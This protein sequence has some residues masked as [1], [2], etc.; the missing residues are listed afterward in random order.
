MI[1]LNEIKLPLKATKED[2]EKEAARLLKI[3]KSD[4][5][6]LSVYRKSLDSRKKHDIHFVYSVDIE[7]QLNEKSVI[8]PLPRNRASII[9]KYSYT[10]PQVKR[11]SQFRP[12]VVGFGPAGMFSALLLAKAGL[13]PLVLERGDDVD[14]R[15]K[16]VSNFWENKILDESS[17]V[18]FG[19]G[20]A[21]T[22]SDGK[23]TTGI[24]NSLCRE[25]LLRFV[26]YGAPEEI[27]WNKSA[28]IGTDKLRG[29]VK[30]I[31]KRII[32]LGGEVK[33]GCQMTGIIKA[34]GCVHGISY[35]D[36]NSSKI[37]FE[38]DTIILA[39][40]HSARDTYEYL[41]K[42]GLEIERKAFSVGLRIEHPQ[43]YI[44]KCQY[45][46]EYKNPLL[47]A[48]E[49]KLSDHPLHGRGA[50]TFCMCP[51][52]IVVNA[53]S[54]KGGVTVNGMS[55]FARDAENANSAILVGLEP[56]LFPSEHSLS[57]MYLQREIERKAFSVGGGYFPT[58]QL[59]KDFLNDTPS[60]K[61]GGVTPSCPTGVVF[62]NI[63]SILPNWA[64]DTISAAIYSFDRKLRGF[65]LPEAVLTAPETRSSAPIRIKRD[66]FMN[67]T[68]LIGLYP[69]GEGAGYAGG[70]VSAAVDGMKA[71]EQI[72][73]GGYPY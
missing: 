43:E 65:N 71:A 20:G 11:V 1:R 73:G 49:Y 62:G 67:A 5:L 58:S 61:A 19:E 55:E 54:E 25:V 69:C 14:T 21:G 50:Y 17:N 8:S 16:K 6:S 37:D 52:G 31:R 13:N 59:L 15:I 60:K 27:L 33:F 18:Q 34:N 22:F 42:A 26:Q 29:V 41:Y 35:V 56:S 68:R 7:T 2:I 44:N 4:I 30:A 47:P 23:L 48:A 10:L 40:G 64:S 66:E 28:H 9:E 39:I 72:I 3:N 53:A 57:G 51:G 63:R 45:S 38:T 12:V 70:I 24:K 32:E 46:K 36:K